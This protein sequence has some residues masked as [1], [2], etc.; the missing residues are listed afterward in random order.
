MDRFEFPYPTDPA[1]DRRTAYLCMEFGI[2]QA[3]KT[4]AGGLG[5]LTGSVVRS[6]YDLKM[7]LIGVGILWTQGYYDQRRKPDQTMEVQFAEKRYDFLQETHY[8]F[9]IRV[10]GQPVNVAIYYLPPEVFGTA[11]VFFLTTDIPENDHLSRCL[12]HRL[13]DSNPEASVAASMLLGLGAHRLM[14]EIGWEPDLYHMNESHALPVAFALHR[15]L[16]DIAETRR[17]LVFTNHTPEA[18]GNPQNSCSMLQRMGYFGELPMETVRSITC[19]EGST[20]DHTL[21]ALRLSRIANGVSRMHV[22]TLARIWKDAS[23]ICPVT[24][25]TNAQKAAYWQDEDFISA[26]RKNDPASVRAVKTLRKKHLFEM[27]AD[28]TGRIMDLSVCTLVFAKRF[29]GYKRPDL[30]LHRMER[31]E[32]LLTQ[33]RFPIQIIWAG[34]PYPQDFN[35]IGV[36]DRIVGICRRLPNCAILTGYELQLSRTLKK[37][38]DLWLNVPRLTHEAS[39]TS[40]MAAAMCGAVNLALPDG[41][42]PEFARHF[43]NGFVIPPCDTDLPED[44]QDDLDADSLIDIL[45]RE[46]LPMFYGEPDAWTGMAMQAARD[47]L[48]RFDSDRLVREYHE[49]L[50]REDGLTQTDREAWIAQTRPES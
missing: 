43:I 15:Q 39:G 29:A 3:L 38:A 17:R 35:A 32:Q 8:R 7:P 44:R 24:S 31:F 22:R 36:F 47:I 9:H 1:F 49:R 26:V 23:D 2:D 13:Y 21:A 33:R 45:E 19:Q 10:S 40:G 18:A 34:K 27:V 11:P 37:G 12:S 48:P 42:Y 25:V 30:F 20:F 16:G 5:F 4:Y 50:Y 6:A 28:Q 46:V 41:W 14:H